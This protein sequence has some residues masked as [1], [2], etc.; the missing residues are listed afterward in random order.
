MKNRKNRCAW[1]P[2]GNELYIT[3]HDEE[4]GVPVFNDRKMFEF[5]V[6]ESAQAGLSWITVLRKREAYR[7]AFA[8]FNPV[9]VARFGQ[10]DIGKLLQNEGIIRNRMK[11][12]AAV[13]NAKQFLNIQK[14]FGS[15]YLYMWEFVNNKQIDGRRKTIKDIPAVSKEAELL[16]KD[17][18]Q[19][20]FK[21]FGPTICYAH[22]QAVG[23]VNDHT[24][25]CFR[26]KKVKQGILKKSK[27]IK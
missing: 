9:R 18:K 25:N 5:L 14:E 2:E 8:N 21:F 7:K 24:I 20:G 23:M 11:I 12:E 3:Y 22:M 1:V 4:W 27:L 10:K 13:N 6:L 26:H 15:F 17:M 19:R 16:A